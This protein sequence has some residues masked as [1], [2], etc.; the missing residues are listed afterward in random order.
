MTAEKLKQEVYNWIP[1]KP[2]NWRE[3][4]AV[5]NYIDEV[6]GVAR[7]AQFQ[8][9]VDCFHDDEEIDNFIKACANII[10]EKY[11]QKSES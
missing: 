1:E 2:K 7:I 10:T 5:F 3:G 11:E 9:Q 4:Q 6:Y 8:H